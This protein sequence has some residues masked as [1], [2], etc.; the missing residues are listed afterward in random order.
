MIS[1]FEKELSALINRY[2][3]DATASTPDFILAA[4]L[5]DCVASYRRIKTW[6]DLWHSKQ[7]VPVSMQENGPPMTRD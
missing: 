6:T 2:S 7:G 4:Y 5:T 1:Q 3:V